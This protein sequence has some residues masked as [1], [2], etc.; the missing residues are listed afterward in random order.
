MKFA[1]FYEILSRQRYAV[2]YLLFH[3]L[4]KIKQQD[5]QVI[6]F[7]I[8]DKRRMVFVGGQKLIS[9][10]R[11]EHQSHSTVFQNDFQALRLP[12]GR[13]VSTG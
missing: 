2:P 9:K 4:F 13:D 3:Q 8:Q 6:V 12:S 11:L 5:C 7:P 1:K 10:H